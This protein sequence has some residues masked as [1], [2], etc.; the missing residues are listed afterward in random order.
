MWKYNRGEWSEA[1]VFLKL[2]ADGKMFLQNK[3]GER[4]DSSC[5]IKSV[6]HNEKDGALFEFV[7]VDNSVK[8]MRNNSCY[9]T[10]PYSVF[11]EMAAVC[12]DGIINKQIKEKAFPITPIEN[13][14]TNELDL[15]T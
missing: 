9:N 12:A 6:I 14:Y 10:I 13:F 2:L 8:C 4:T 15:S 3:D 1:Y 7:R 5:S 11:S